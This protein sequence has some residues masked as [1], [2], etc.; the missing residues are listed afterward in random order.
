MGATHFVD[1]QWVKTHWS[2]RNVTFFIYPLPTLN[3]LVK[4]KNL[5][6]NYIKNFKRKFEN[7]VYLIS[8]TGDFLRF[9]IS[10]CVYQNF[11]GTRKNAQLI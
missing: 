7:I 2:W 9:F 11:Q 3:L 6:E 5:L 4:V 8:A 1:C 10:S